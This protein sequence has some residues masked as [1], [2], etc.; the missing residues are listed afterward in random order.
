M[1]EPLYI[2]IA[3]SIRQQILRGERKPGDRLPPVRQLTETFHCTPGT[4]QRAYHELAKQG[5]VISRAGQGTQVQGQTT[6]ISNTPL[7]RATLVNRA[8]TFL[9]EALSAGYSL[10][11]IAQA[12]TMATDRWRVADNTPFSPPKIDLNFSGSHDPVI[13]LIADHIQEIIPGTE[14]HVNFTGSLGGLIAMVEGRADFAGIHLWD[15]ATREYNAPFVQRLLPGRKIALITLCHRRLGLLLRPENRAKVHS[16]HDL[17]QP[18]IQYINRQSGSGT[19]VWFDA[20]LKELGILPSAINGYAKEAHTH[21]EIARAIAEE[22]ATVGLGLESLALAFGLDFIFLAREQYDLV[23]P[24]ESFYLPQFQQL[25]AW[26]QSSPARQS[27]LALGGY[28]TTFSG[29]IRWVS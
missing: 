10:E 21:S 29:S 27:I 12:F 8:E 20:R 11:E 25:I 24:A 22:Q 5:L 18:D 17:T 26:L 14:L 13:T 2:Q 15:E 19:R 3:E 23:V 4:V 1:E 6:E 16:L 7:R 9:L 28:D